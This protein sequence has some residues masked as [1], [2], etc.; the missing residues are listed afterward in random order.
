MESFKVFDYL[1]CT[2]HIV[3]TSVTM[4]TNDIHRSCHRENTNK[5][6]TCEEYHTTCTCIMLCYKQP[7]KLLFS[8]LSRF[9]NILYQCVCSCC[10]AKASKPTHKTLCKT[11]FGK[12]SCSEYSFF[13]T[14]VC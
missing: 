7:L 8:V 1:I 13:C 4:T 14:W 2:Y 10:Q 3:T 12:T 9:N 5:Q 6:I 11:H